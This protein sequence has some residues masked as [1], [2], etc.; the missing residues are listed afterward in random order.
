MLLR[1]LQRA[2]E[3]L[4]SLF[5]EHWLYNKGSIFLVSTVAGQDQFLHG[6]GKMVAGGSLKEGV[7]CLNTWLI[8]RGKKATEHRAMRKPI[9]TEERHKGG[10]C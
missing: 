5:V 9:A 8:E 4:H 3:L 6:R 1:E 2:I 10:G 7:Y